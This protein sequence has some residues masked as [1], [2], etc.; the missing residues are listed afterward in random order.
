VTT[1][2]DDFTHHFSSRFN[3]EL[4]NLRSRVLAMGSTVEHQINDAVD[5]LETGNANM[6]RAVIGGD[7][8]VNALEVYLDEE[9]GRILAR[10]QPA[11]GDLRLVVAIIKT[12]TDIERIGDQAK[13]VAR[14]ALEMANVHTELE[15]PDLREL[16]GLVRDMVHKA[17]RAFAM[18][19]VDLALE[20]APADVLV[21]REYESLMNQLTKLMME[22][23]ESISWALHLVWAARALERAGDHAK[24]IAEYLI[25]I[26][27][28]T[29]VRHISVEARER[30]VQSVS[31]KDDASH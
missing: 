19:D 22:R 18:M 9:C 31:G 4:E 11:A 20:V 21:D 13:G 5:A 15:R 28:G 17:L 30:K 12:V 8:Q 24:N 10:R 23:P 26:V 27:Q 14:V 1:Q 2:R 29:D 7:L 3:Q 6:A 16:G 25:Y